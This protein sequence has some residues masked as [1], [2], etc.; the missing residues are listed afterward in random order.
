MFESRQRLDLFQKLIHCSLGISQWTYNVKG[1]LLSSSP[2]AAEENNCFFALENSYE[3]ALQAGAVQDYP[4]LITNSLNL[5]WIAAY[6]KEDGQLTY[7]H[8]I[9]AR[10]ADTGSPQ[11]IWSCSFPGF[12]CRSV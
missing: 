10:F 12:T 4:L 11:E 2:D 1:E 5:M 9:R 6:E 7:I 3:D 8:V